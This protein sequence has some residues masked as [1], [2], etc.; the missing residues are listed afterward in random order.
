MFYAPGAVTIGRR[1]NN[2]LVCNDISVSG[3][4]WSRLVVKPRNSLI[5]KG[6]S[7]PGFSKRNHQ[8]T[9][10]LALDSPFLWSGSILVIP[11]TAVFPN[12]SI[13]FI[14]AMEILRVAS[15]VGPETFTQ[16][17]TWES[18]MLGGLFLGRHCEISISETLK[19]SDCSTNGALT[20]YDFT[21][22]QRKIS[23][24]HMALENT[25]HFRRY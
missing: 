22:W 21:K 16:H 1:P 17:P 12:I 23:E 18:L 15:D 19:I 9:F 6:F 20:A 2:T 5:R 3:R 24:Q 11:V 7:Q 8:R 13:L 14:C 10:Y 4:P 25:T